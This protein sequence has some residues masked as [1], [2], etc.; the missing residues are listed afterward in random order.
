MAGSPS[1]VPETPERDT[2]LVLDD[3][4]GRL[5][6]AWRETEEKDTDRGIV[7]RHLMEGQYASPVR[8]VAFNTAAGWS[9]DVTE[10]IAGEL[11]KCC[12]DE[13]YFPRS[14]EAFLAHHGR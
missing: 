8:I 9:R 5:G 7:I 6:R 3:F 4:G 12:N 13:G 2:Y 11:W 10:E 1:I 14:L